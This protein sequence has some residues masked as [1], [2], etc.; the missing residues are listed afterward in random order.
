MTTDFLTLPDELQQLAS[1]L[2]R[3]LRRRGYVCE[4]EP[5]LL[6]LPSTPT[7]CAR[8]NH[9][10]HYILARQ[11]YSKDE[12]EQWFRYACSCSTDT[13]ISLCCP[14]NHKISTAEFDVLENK[15]IG[16]FIRID[17]GFRIVPEARD[18][19]FHA[20]APDRDALKPKVRQLLGEALDRLEDGD[21]RPAFEEACTVLEEECRRYLLKN[22][23]MGRVKYQTGNKLKVPTKAEIKKMTLGALKD[24]FC[25]LVSQNQVE[26]NLCSALT[27]LNPDR[28]LRAHHRRKRAAEAAL[29]RR[30][31]PHFW[32]IS[33]S[34]TLLV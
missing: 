22:L 13:R 24:V 19:A 4:V 10:T 15:R 9:E 3:E 28:I 25:R 2:V 20:R 16:A 31:G 27:K 7:I 11:V 29:R 12:I 6:E 1:D 33:N 18:L 5:E 26:A 32:L 17:G 21:W 34:L 14:A 30:V 23:K 8:R